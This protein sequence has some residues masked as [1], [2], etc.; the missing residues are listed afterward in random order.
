[1]DGR[2]DEGK[3][4]VHLQVQADKPCDLLAWWP[5]AW[6]PAAAQITGPQWLDRNSVR[7]LPVPGDRFVTYGPERFVRLSLPAGESAVALSE[8]K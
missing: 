3:R 4:E 5:E 7:S 8:A 6:G 1:V 2:A